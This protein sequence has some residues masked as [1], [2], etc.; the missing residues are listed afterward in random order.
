L[1]VGLT[2][3]HRRYTL[4]YV[5]LQKY[6]ILRLFCAKARGGTPP[7]G[8]V[9]RLLVLAW[10]PSYLVWLARRYRDDVEF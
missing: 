6:G 9:D 1:V 8:W 3:V 4:P 7:P 10:F 5:Y 2:F